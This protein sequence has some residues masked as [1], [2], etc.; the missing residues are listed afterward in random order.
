MSKLINEAA[1]VQQ[2]VLEKL[3]DNLQAL[4]RDLQR[5]G[6]KPG[7]DLYISA[8]ALFLHW[9]EQTVTPQAMRASLAAL[10]STSSDEQLR[11]GKIFQSWYQRYDQ[12]AV[13]KPDTAQQLSKPPKWS[14]IPKISWR[15]RLS[16]AT[17]LC[18]RQRKPASICR[19][20]KTY[21]FAV[22]ALLKGDNFSPKR[23][24]HH[25]SPLLHT[26]PVVRHEWFY[27]C[28]RCPHRI[29]AKAFL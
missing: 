11:F 23:V 18:Y 28:V 25:L 1:V 17:G 10:F 14:K 4:L 7:I 13:H 29:F 8:Q 6:Y 22:N 15:I 3:Q 12:P 24:F 9:Q 2:V 21:L 20:P 19:R 27:T 26:L 5:N 16:V